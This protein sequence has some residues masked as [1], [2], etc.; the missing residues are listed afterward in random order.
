LMN[1]LSPRSMLSRGAVPP[2]RD[3]Y[4]WPSFT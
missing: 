3:A 1:G 2:T 4:T